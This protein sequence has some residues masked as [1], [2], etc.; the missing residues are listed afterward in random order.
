MVL[1]GIIWFQLIPIFIHLSGIDRGICTNE[2]KFGV[3]DD[4][5]KF[6]HSTITLQT[7]EQE[8]EK[9]MHPYSEEI[10]AKLG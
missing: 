2:E 9:I 5:S 10:S 1:E 8:S 4:Q 6:Q 3:Q 7:Q